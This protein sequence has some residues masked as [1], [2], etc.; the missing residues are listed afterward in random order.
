MS[1]FRCGPAP[2]TTTSVIRW[3]WAVLVLALAWPATASA[4]PNY[5]AFDA[6]SFSDGATGLEMAYT[7][8][9]RL[10]VA[11]EYNSKNY[12]LDATELP[13]TDR[14]GCGLPGGGFD[15]G[16]RSGWVRFLPGVAGGVR[17]DVSTPAHRS[18][19]VGWWSAPA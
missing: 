13:P 3:G 11:A 5:D 19:V 9:E 2:G 17:S 1:R 10:Q 8:A 14:T 7:S 6:A 4:D 16:G 15:V 12:T 18:V